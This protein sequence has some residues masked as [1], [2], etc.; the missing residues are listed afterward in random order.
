MGEGHL[1]GT[2]T[3]R[4]MKSARK[5]APNVAESEASPCTITAM[6]RYGALMPLNEEA[7]ALVA[8]SVYWGTK[9]FRQGRKCG[10]LMCAS[11]EFKRPRDTAS[12]TQPTGTSH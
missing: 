5:V 11:R 1:A 6:Q 4:N 9:Y 7:I 12:N 3:R 10:R 8:E 2:I